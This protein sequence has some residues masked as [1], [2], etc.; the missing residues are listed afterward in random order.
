MYYRHCRGP[1]YEIAI[2]QG[3]AK[4]HNIKPKGWREGGRRVDSS[5]LLFKDINFTNFS[6]NKLNYQIKHIN[7]IKAD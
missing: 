1:K 2:P 7:L 4:H 3:G 6:R 5:M